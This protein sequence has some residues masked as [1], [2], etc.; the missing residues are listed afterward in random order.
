M[1]ALSTL[2]RGAAAAALLAA[3]LAAAALGDGTAWQSLAPAPAP[4]QEASYAA[5]GGEIYLAGGNDLGQ[6]RYDPAADRWAPVADLPASLTGLDHV[7]GVPVDDRIVYAGGL[8]K[9]EYPFPVSGETELYDPASDGFAPGA[10]MPSPRA[11]GG[12]AA[13]HGKLIYAGGLG[14]EGAV[15]RVDMYDP[16]SDEWTRL[17]DMPRP[18]EHFQA[19][20]VGDRLY[21]I[22]GRR[23]YGVE[24]G[25]GVEDIAAVDALQLPAD[26]AELA[27]AEWSAG[28]ASLPTPRGGLGVAAVGGCIYAVG[29]ERVL[30]GPDEVTG[31]VESYDTVGGE[32]REL[33]SLAIP[34]HG[35]QA[36]T[37]AG[38][39]YV[40]GGGTKA[41][42]SEPTAAHE[43][44]DV[45]A[46]APCVA[47]EGGEE[48]EEEPEPAPDPRPKD[49]SSAA[50]REPA[51][52]DSLSSGRRRP[53]IAHLAVRPRRVV[54]GR[55]APGG[56]PK[57]V[58]RLTRAGKITLRLPGT[59]RFGRRLQAGRNV[60][61]LP[62][63]PHGR[64]LPRGRHRL[65][66]TPLPASGDGPPAST[67]F[68]VVR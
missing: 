60:L 17:E 55:H 35:I 65:V 27:S 2:R 40:A 61:P 48:T 49:G 7:N 33:P 9:W 13:W 56:R 59:F 57:V 62:L 32:W 1:K 58:V 36:A 11:A 67:R 16:A 50:A 10:D 66:A 6:E 52:V 14:P 30:S 31:R 21:A 22:G 54:L 15:A 19:A 5:L 34:R 18:R 53:L 28:V 20:I 51:P 3:A 63:H 25:I 39:I 4:R 41:F 68:R 26:D 29:G 43:A 64:P 42:D 12:V 38:T 44:L 8:E 46:A 47:V 37:I 24:G 23:T 45:S